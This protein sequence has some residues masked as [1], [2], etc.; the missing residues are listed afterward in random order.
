MNSELDKK[1]KP[2]RFEQVQALLV[3]YRVFRWQEPPRT[4]PA[5][6]QASAFLLVK[7]ST[8]TNP[9]SS[10]SKF[11]Q[12]AWEAVSICPKVLESLKGLR[13]HRPEV[14]KTEGV[15][16]RFAKF[17]GKHL[18]RSLFFIKFVDRSVT[19]SKKSLRHRCFT[20]NFSKFLRTH[21]S[22]EQ[23]R[24]LLLEAHALAN[25]LK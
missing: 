10:L 22:I 20:V 15:L 21:F 19:L 6:I 12:S 3:A 14:F 13:G 9:W 8:K 2:I 17:T 23:H 18:C 7:H 25:A 5:T 24:W 4:H 11:K 1:C 16:Q